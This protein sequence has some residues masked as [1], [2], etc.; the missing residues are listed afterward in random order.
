ME[1]FRPR[2]FSK[3]HDTY[4]QSKGSTY[5]FFNCAYVLIGQN[6]PV[7]TYHIAQILEPFPLNCKQIG[8]A[9]TQVAT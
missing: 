5:H 7:A 9:F 3:G 4:I 2:Y 8:V 1:R 6:I